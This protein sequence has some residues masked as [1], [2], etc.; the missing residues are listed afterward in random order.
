MHIKNLLFFFGATIC[1]L[2]ILSSN[3]EN[4]TRSEKSWHKK[5]RKVSQREQIKY[6]KQSYPSKI[7]FQYRIEVLTW[8]PTIKR[9]YVLRN[10]FSKRKLYWLV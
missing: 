1:Q 6:S 2:L 4:I 3:V 9:E 5:K 7:F 8:Q 10:R